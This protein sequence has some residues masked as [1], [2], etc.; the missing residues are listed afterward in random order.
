MKRYLLFLFCLFSASLN[1]Q[2]NLWT[3]INESE[4]ESEGNF[5]AKKDPYTFFVGGVFRDS[6]QIH[7]FSVKSSYNGKSFFLLHS[8]IEGEIT[9]IKTFDAEIDFKVQDFKTDKD[10]NIYLLAELTGSVYIA[11]FKIGS[12]TLNK[13]PI[14]IKLNSNGDLLHFKFL[15]ESPNSKFKAKG[16]DVTKLGEVV[17]AIELKEL[18]EIDGKEFRPKV[19]ED[20]LL[21]HLN[22]DFTIKNHLQLSSPFKAKSEMLKIGKSGNM[23]LSGEFDGRIEIKDDF[24]IRGS[25]KQGFVLKLDSLLNPIWAFSDFRDPKGLKI[26]ALQEDNENNLLIAGEF[27]IAVILNGVH[28]IRSISQKKDILIIKLDS[29]GE[30]QWFHN[31]NPLN[32][33]KP[34]GL[35]VDK[36]NNIYLF[37]EYKQGFRYGYNNDNPLVT[38]CEDAA[39][40]KGSFLVVYDKNGTVKAAKS[41]SGVNEAKIGDLI[42]DFKNDIYITGDFRGALALDTI[43]LIERNSKK[44]F[45]LAKIDLQSC[46]YN[47]DYSQ[48]FINKDIVFLHQ[49]FP[50]PTSGETY[51]HFHAAQE[52]SVKISLFDLNGRKVDTVF[53]DE[54]TKI[55]NY[56]FPYRFPDNCMPG[57]YLLILESGD[58]RITKKIALVR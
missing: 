23:Y 42:V 54:N 4:H 30:L 29:E 2:I 11:N 51:I 53:E 35:V 24:E 47:H 55:A 45:F 56:V 57:I 58:F 26:K 17:M 18:I 21:I 48:D 28:Q 34:K 16:F 22:T 9:S 3:H 19:K 31:A 37:G 50:N 44:T 43:S 1:G 27:E 41:I 20:I 36:N 25:A 33:A 12:D 52:V 39:N 8:D 38:T 13:E 5:L 46:A 32:E 10:A 15:K 6:I 49:N 7:R 40:A 14:L